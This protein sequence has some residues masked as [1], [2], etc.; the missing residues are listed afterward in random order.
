MDKD[1]LPK[2]SDAAEAGQESGYTT[3]V[4][5]NFYLPSSRVDDFFWVTSQSQLVSVARESPAHALTLHR[6]F[7]LH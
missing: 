2:S 4:A 1:G 7:P 5:L 6:R 3:T